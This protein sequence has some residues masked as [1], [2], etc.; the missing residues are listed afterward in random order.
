MVNV[1]IYS[2]TLELSTAVRSHAERCV[3][4]TLGALSSIVD[5][6]RITLED[7]NGTRG[8]VD[9]D[10]RVQLI[11][12][13]SG[14]I[15]RQAR[16]GDSYHAIANAISLAAEALRRENKL[17]RKRVTRSAGLTMLEAV[18]SILR[19][20]VVLVWEIPLR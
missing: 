17:R 13:Q 20:I 16:D 8:G 18:W 5:R 9:K 15:L 2:G 11:L 10:C 7:I 19:L 1:S 6:V 3:Q 4:E 12:K 14:L